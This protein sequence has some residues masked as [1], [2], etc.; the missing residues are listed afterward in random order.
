MAKANGQHFM[1]FMKCGPNQSTSLVICV[2]ILEIFAFKHHVC[3]HYIKN[4]FSKNVERERTRER[5]NM[6]IFHSVHIFQSV[7]ITF[8][9]SLFIMLCL[10]ISLLAKAVA[11]IHQQQQK[12]GRREMTNCPRSFHETEFSLHVLFFIL[13]HFYDG[14]STKF[15]PF[16]VQRP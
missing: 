1:L 13:A 16:S 12:S 2:R 9:C 15:Y 10:V 11:N 14:T 3:M 4:I 5:G 6:Y 8:H 7:L